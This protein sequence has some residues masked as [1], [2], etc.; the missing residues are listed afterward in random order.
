MTQ[1]PSFEAITAIAVVGS[2]LPSVDVFQ[3]LDATLSDLAVDHE[4]VIIANSV[5]AEVAQ[6]LRMIAESVPNVTVHFLAQYIDRD[7]AV[8]VGID[9][10]LGDWIVVL[11][12]TKAEVD[13]LA[14]VLTKAGPYEIVF[15]GARAPKDIPDGYRWA[16]RAYFWLFELV[17]GARVD[18]PAPRIRVY[19]RAAARHLASVLDGEF[20]LRSLTFSGAFPGTRETIMGLPQDD[21]D[22]PT[23]WRALRKGVRG[24]LNATAVP[25]RAVIGTALFGGLV[26]TVSSIYTLLVYLF[27]EDVAPGWATLSLQ[28][29]IMMFLFS[30]MFA[31]LAEYVLKVY[32]TI[33]P[34]RGVTV[35][36]EIRSP[37]RR[38]SNRLNVIGTDGSF[39]LGA[40]RDLPPATPESEL[41][42]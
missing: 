32:R 25:L 33:A 30:I 34:R 24:L 19:S 41:V 6:G 29:S 20:A 35:V 18:W 16:A 23:P 17:T 21:L 28:I 2:Q 10:A 12:P 27:K 22:L 14:Y 1:N 26:A 8:L 5:S 38:Q 36:R 4:I 31:L 9:H 11:T 37:L 15:A 7:T 40:P 42:Q 13:S 39:Q 3:S